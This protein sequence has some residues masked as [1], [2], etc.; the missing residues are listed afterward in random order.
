M[1]LI[2]SAIPKLFSSPNHITGIKPISNTPRASDDTVRLEVNCGFECWMGR[3]E[4]GRL[5]GYILSVVRLGFDL[6]GSK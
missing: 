2:I 5:F 3:A 1:W 4:E 6:L